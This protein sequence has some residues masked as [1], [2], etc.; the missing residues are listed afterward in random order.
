MGYKMSSGDDPKASACKEDV[1]CRSHFNF[2]V[3]NAKL[4]D[5]Q[6]PFENLPFLVWYIRVSKEERECASKSKYV[7]VL[8]TTASDGSRNKHC[9]FFYSIKAADVCG[10]K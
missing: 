2:T 8:S 5:G 4:T 3:L 9:S 6:S 7:N 10:N 1:H